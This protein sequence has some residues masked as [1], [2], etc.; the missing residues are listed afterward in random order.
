M[1]VYECVQTDTGKSQQ[2]SA[3]VLCSHS[4]FFV[5]ERRQS[6][7]YLSLPL[8]QSEKDKTKPMDSYTGFHGIGDTNCA[9]SEALP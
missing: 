9:G 7:C 1:D 5:N 3:V 4:S 6:L 2:R 8:L